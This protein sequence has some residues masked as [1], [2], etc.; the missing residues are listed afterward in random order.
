MG[1][2]VM[3]GTTLL[4]LQQS[5]TSY[6]NI[7]FCPVSHHFWPQQT[8]SLASNQNMALTCAFFT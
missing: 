3:L 8:T 1:T 2:H 4:H 7:T 6:L 5:P